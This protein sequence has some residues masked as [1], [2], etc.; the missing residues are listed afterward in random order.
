MFSRKNFQ[1]IFKILILFL[2]LFFSFQTKLL[3]QNSSAFNNVRNT[4]GSDCKTYDETKNVKGTCYT[5]SYDEINEKCHRGS[6][7]FDPFN[8]S[9]VDLEWNYGNQSCL[10]FMF[11][12]G[13]AL[14]GAFI[15]C[16]VLCPG[17]PAINDPIKNLAKS[18]F[19]KKY[20]R[21]PSLFR[22]LVIL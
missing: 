9:N 21:L 8:S 19:Q 17:P 4:T 3:A 15:G 12:A 2:N 16:R 5:S 20:Q 14:E 1:H 11:G 22:E 13:V 6:F 18:D 10:G 7:I